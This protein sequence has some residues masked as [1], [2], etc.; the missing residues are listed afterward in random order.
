M[1]LSNYFIVRKVGSNVSW[2][3]RRFDSHVGYNSASMLEHAL[4]CFDFRDMRVV[5]DLKL[6][7]S[8]TLRKSE[9][10]TKEERVQNYHL[11]LD[12]AVRRA[13]AA[14][15]GEPPVKSLRKSRLEEFGVKPL[16]D[17]DITL[18][19]VRAAEAHFFLDA[20]LPINLVS[21]ESYIAFMRTLFTYARSPLRPNYLPPSRESLSKS[22]FGSGGIVEK[23]VRSGMSDL[24]NVRFFTL[25]I[26]GRAACRVES[27]KAVVT[28]PNF[29]TLGDGSGTIAQVL[30]SMYKTRGDKTGITTCT[31][32]RE[33]IFESSL[34]DDIDSITSRIFAVCTDGFSG[35]FPRF[36]A[37]MPYCAH[38]HVP[39]RVLFF[40]RRHERRLQARARTRHRAS[41]VRAAHHVAV[42]V[43]HWHLHAGL[44]QDA[45]EDR[46][47]SARG[48]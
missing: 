17:T 20:L 23:V 22:I 42:F 35:S 26:D 29:A 30:L 46:F 5:N 44:P 48:V 3:C 32:L 38:W 10:E 1:T 47:D 43:E 25:G 4:K 2:V 36:S 37:R 15:V 6:L 24:A 39:L 41:A 27:N 9:G 13:R 12:T 16:M 40:R 34:D 21:R 14:S 31:R 19:Q 18:E 7:A 8:K 28:G 11:R 45:R 33:L